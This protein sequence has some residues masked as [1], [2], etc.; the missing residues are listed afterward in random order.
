MRSKTYFYRDLYCIHILIA[1]TGLDF[2]LSF[3]F[4][5]RIDCLPQQV[6]KMSDLPKA[7]IS[8][9]CDKVTQFLSWKTK[10]IVTILYEVCESRSPIFLLYV[11]LCCNWK[12]FLFLLN[13]LVILSYEANLYVK[14]S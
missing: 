8:L 2:K 9:S 1:K 7:E 5:K 14:R 4:V 3:G 11:S 10:S 6:C 13:Y 12:I